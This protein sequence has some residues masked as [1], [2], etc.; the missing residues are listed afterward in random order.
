MTF[1]DIQ[2]NEEVKAAFRTM[3][4]SGRIP[5]AILLHEDDGGGA[6]PLVLAFLQY[7]Y[8]E[9]R[10]GGDACCSCPSCNRVSKLIHPDIHFIFP[11]SAGTSFADWAPKWRPLLA[12]NPSFTEN[13]LAEALGIEG[14]SLV[15]AVSEAKALLETLSLGAVEGG[16]RS[17]VIYLP[18]KMNAE[19]ANKLLK[20][21]EE[22]P[23]QTLLLFISHSPESVLQTI[24]SRCQRI[25]IL[26]EE[27]SSRTVSG[28]SVQE[29]D[30]L[31]CSLLDAVVSRNLLSC[32]EAGEEMAELPS[33]ESMKAFCKFASSS[34]RGIFLA[35][36]GL[37]K[38]QGTECG[39]AAGRASSLKK[40]FPRLALAEI[41][42]ASM[43]I[44]RNVNSK[45]VF[46]ELSV[47]LFGINNS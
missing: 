14:K 18:E 15:I 16:Y 11:S 33:R 31:F 9:H 41:D 23:A 27:N 6:M 39:G 1:S 36:Q 4:D 24:Q 19:T 25:R 29:Y 30:R 46:V 13:E 43:L 37:D 20:M 47:K 35:Q 22:P 26:P 45:I 10:S 28:E 38:L 8:C 40:T 3:V 44:G 12:S 32:I 21:I 7:L 42:R 5:H 2:G 17:V 34:L